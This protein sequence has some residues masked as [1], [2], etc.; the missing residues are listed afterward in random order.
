MT[1]DTTQKRPKKS[2]RRRALGFAIAFAISLLV[3][4]VF[5][6]VGSEATLSAAARAQTG[7]MMALSKAS[8]W[9]VAKTYVAAFDDIV[10][11]GMRRSYID[12]DGRIQYTEPKGGLLGF[13]WAPLKAFVQTLI[14]F[15]TTGGVVGLLQI[16]MGAMAL[17]LLNLRLSKGKRMTFGVP[18]IANVM[19]LP[20]ATIGTA[21]LLAVVLKLVMLAALVALSWVTQFAA[22]AAGATGV[23]G[24][25]WYCAQK[26]GEKG[27]EHALTP[28]I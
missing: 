16:A 6:F 8:P 21:S 22:G 27:A 12:A 1:D 10:A 24:F 13:F 18:P 17:G 26:L 14:A 28:K 15:A 11:Q 23:A 7:W 25:C 2:W 9:G 20:L 3:G 4:R 5:E 19:V